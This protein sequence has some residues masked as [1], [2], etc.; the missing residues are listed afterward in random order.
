VLVWITSVVATGDGS[1]AE[2]AEFTAVIEP[3]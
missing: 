2:I 1:R 3:A